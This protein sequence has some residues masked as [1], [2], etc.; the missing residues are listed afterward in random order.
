V[1][2][3]RHLEAATALRPDLPLLH[4]AWSFYWGALADPLSRANQLRELEAEVRVTGDLGAMAGLAV[5]YAELQEDD[6]ALGW[7]D[8]FYG[9]LPSSSHYGLALTCA[10]VALR[11]RRPSLEPLALERFWHARTPEV[12]EA[13][14][15]ADLANALN[16]ACRPAE[17][18]AEAE[19]ALAAGC[20]RPGDG[21]R[22][23]ALVMLGRWGEA[24]VPPPTG[25]YWTAADRHHRALAQAMTGDL[26]GALQTS[27]ASG[28]TDPL[29]S[30]VEG[31]R[32]VER[33]DEALFLLNA[34]LAAGTP[35]AALA[36]P[37]RCETWR[38][39]EA[40]RLAAAAGAYA[41]ALM[42]D[43]ALERS[44]RA[45]RADPRHGGAWQARVY[46]LSVAGRLDEAASEG[47]RAL[48][49]GVADAS[50]RANLGYV[51]EQRG[52]CERAVPLFQLVR[53]QKP[54][55]AANHTN[56]AKCLDL[57]D[58]EEEADEAWR[59]VQGGRATRSAGWLLGGLAVGAVLGYLL[60]K[61]AL[62][63]LWPGRFGHLRFP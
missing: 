26:A 19:K 33:Q 10:K 55:R 32:Q 50:L 51:Y 4:V 14:M 12:G 5:A 46:A 59:F 63:R 35:A 25:L 9:A 54:L 48:A 49:M 17:G 6:R 42:T 62:I 57:L 58:R 44:E 24:T 18:L 53:A 31:T 47:E 41:T 15:H 52:E 22:R 28:Y 20:V 43:E 8:R 1:G 21:Q 3:R 61:L 45:L 34:Q 37:P 30:S 39:T 7:C 40:D 11:A 2:Y 60:A 38:A 16:Q 29:G 13:C 36:E 23:E 56:L 27:A